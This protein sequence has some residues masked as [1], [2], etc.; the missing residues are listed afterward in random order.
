MIAAQS[1]K[2][3]ADMN[4]PVPRPALSTQSSV[5]SSLAASSG[6]E[7]HSP[8][9][10]RQPVSG[11]PVSGNFTAQKFD[12]DMPSPVNFYDCNINSEDHK[13]CDQSNEKRILT[14]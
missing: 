10:Q 11:S 3:S 6:D 8:S 1:A 4:P 12:E 9:Y 5:G 7:G 2:E 14:K 13:V